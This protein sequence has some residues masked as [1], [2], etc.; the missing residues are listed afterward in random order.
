MEPKKTLA[1]LLCDPVE[2]ARVAMLNDL[3]FHVEMQVRGGSLMLA[4][5][6]SEHEKVESAR[7]L[8]L[9]QGVL[10]HLCQYLGSVREHLSLRTQPPAKPITQEATA[11]GIVL[12]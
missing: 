4:G 7:D 11:E 5:L 12:H 1:D 6:I 8:F 9:V 2:S 3:L 10:D